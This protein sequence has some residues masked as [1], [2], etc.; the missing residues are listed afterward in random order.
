M[1]YVFYPPPRPLSCVVHPYVEC[2]QSTYISGMGE[3]IFAESRNNKRMKSCS[4]KGKPFKKVHGFF[5]KN[6]LIIFDIAFLYFP[7]Y[8]FLDRGPL[9]LKVYFCEY[10][11]DVFY[12]FSIF[13]SLFW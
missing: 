9:M 5:G 3:R 13:I 11:L 2:P 10:I 8:I 4:F 1:I 7:H 12:F 6:A